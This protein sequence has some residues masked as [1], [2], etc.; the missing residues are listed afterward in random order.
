MLF[1]E[2]MPKYLFSVSY[3]PEGMKGVSKEGGSKRRVA[4]DQVIKSVGEKC[5]HFILLSEMVMLTL[6]P[7]FP[8]KRAQW[9]LLPS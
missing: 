5:S 9:L 7:I 4:A 8:I 6:S 2:V 3:S 1:H